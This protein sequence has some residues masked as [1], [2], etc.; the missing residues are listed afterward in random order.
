[1]D[2]VP[3]TFPF[4]I[5]RAYTAAARPGATAVPAAL[6][7][8]GVTARAS[9]DSVHITG[10]RGAALEQAAT[11]L[12]AARVPGGADFTAPPPPTGSLPLYRHPADR[13]AA[14]TGVQAGRMLDVEG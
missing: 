13:N 4:H 8:P 7:P 1:M 5:A 2:A 3:P 12:A 11:R 14:A 9:G 6:T 10:Q